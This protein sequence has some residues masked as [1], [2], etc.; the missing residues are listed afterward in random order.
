MTETG[1]CGQVCFDL[2]RGGILELHEASGSG[3]TRQLGYFDKSTSKQPGR[4][5]RFC[6]LKP[7]S[8]NDSHKKNWYV[9]LSSGVVEEWRIS[10]KDRTTFDNILVFCFKVP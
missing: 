4:N 7:N 3:D 6:F 8:Q 10:N 5:R 9:F 1:V 2:H